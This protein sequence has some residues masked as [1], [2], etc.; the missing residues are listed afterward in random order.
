M[1][2]STWYVERLSVRAD[3]FGA[4]VRYMRRGEWSE[5]LSRAERRAAKRS[6]RR[7][8]YIAGQRA[9]AHRATYPRAYAPPVA[10]ATTPR[11]P[12]P[13]EQVNGRWQLVTDGDLLA[14][15][16]LRRG[17]TAMGLEQWAN[18]LLRADNVRRGLD[19]N[20]D[21][22]R[23]DVIDGDTK[24]LTVRPDPVTHVSWMTGDTLESMRYELPQPVSAAQRKIRRTELANRMLYPVTYY[25]R[26][27][28]HLGDRYEAHTRM[29][30]TRYPL[31]TWLEDTPPRW[32]GMGTR[33]TD[34]H[35][36]GMGGQPMVRLRD[37][38]GWRGHVAVTRG[39]ARGVS[40]TRDT[41]RVAASEARANVDGAATR[42]RLVSV[43]DMSCRSIPRRWSDAT[44]AQ[45]ANAETIEQTIRA[46]TDDLVT[47]ELGE[48]VTIRDG[49]TVVRASGSSYP[50]RDYAR[51]AAL[52]GIALD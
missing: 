49:V 7:A 33:T 40:V 47:I 30:T 41:E 3:A 34:Q 44:D 32:A 15:R 46:A 50:I 26:V 42:G 39:R 43:W 13:S 52:A 5:S 31:T 12:S 17:P 1:T 16:E 6:H 36:E 51:R 4:M 9:L 37:R 25:V 28:D 11:A 23:E 27:R 2:R 8:D 22:Q 14:S 24:R 48:Q 38:V 18:M 45:R 35:Y 21:L 29:V 19:E 20:Q 10:I